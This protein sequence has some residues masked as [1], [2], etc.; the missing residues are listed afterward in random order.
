MFAR[1]QPAAGKGR[2]LSAVNEM[3]RFI[4]RESK[5]KDLLMTAEYRRRTP[6]LAIAIGAMILCLSGV[7]ALG[8][9]DGMKEGFRVGAKV[10]DF[11]LTSLEGK[12]FSL[13]GELGRGPVV[14]VVLRGW[15]GYQC[16]FCT[17][18]FGDFLNHA[19][20]FAKLNATLVFIYPGPAEGLREHAAEFQANRPMPPNFRFATDPE[21]RWV[22]A[23][24]LRWDAKDETS[25]PSTFITDRRGEIRFSSISKVHGA[26]P[27]TQQLLDVV[28]ELASE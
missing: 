5:S 1:L 7:T 6:L 22:S 19:G 27:A 14:L 21:L 9:T 24:G 18:Q 11:N 13:Q 17:R 3:K 10:A 23:H 4:P 12:Q 15:P 26:R 8:Q 28:K 25:F 2:Y 16:P 20:D